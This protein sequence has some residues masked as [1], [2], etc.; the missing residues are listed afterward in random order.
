MT[1]LHNEGRQILRYGIVGVTQ[2]GVMYLIFLALIWAG[3][4]PVL[5]AGLCYLGGVALSYVLNRNWSFSSQAG[6]RQDL[7]K[8]L[9]AYGIGLVASMAGI[10]VLTLWFRPEIAQ[11]F[12]IL[13][14]AGVIYG[15]LRLLRFGN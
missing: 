1:L 4:E 13:F 5:A 15:S 12:N 2:N 10:A 11:L 9:A 6:H 7:P 14:C 3:T 8:F